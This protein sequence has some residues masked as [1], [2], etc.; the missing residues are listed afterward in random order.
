[1][2]KMRKKNS[3]PFRKPDCRRRKRKKNVSKINSF[4]VERGQKKKNRILTKFYSNPKGDDLARVTSTFT[5]RHES[6]RKKIKLSRLLTLTRVVTYVLVCIF[7][8]I[9][10]VL[11][12]I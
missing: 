11:D 8:F 4:P 7:F 3:H 12:H 9:F 10:E 2:P 6:R 1:M 5:V